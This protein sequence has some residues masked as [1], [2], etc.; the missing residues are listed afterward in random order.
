ML[1]PSASKEI[2]CTLGPSS[3]NDAV[4]TRLEELGVSLFRLNLSHTKLKDVAKIIQYVQSRTSVPI[5]LDTEG[6]QIRTGDFVD[7]KIH[8]RENRVIRVHRQ[9]VPGDSNSFNLYPSY[10]IDELEIGGCSQFG[11]PIDE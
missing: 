1:R 4:I 10:I 11:R 5:C 6:A 9:A 2:L 8:L 7:G 3:M